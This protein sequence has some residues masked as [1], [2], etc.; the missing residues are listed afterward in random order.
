MADLVRW[1]LLGGRSLHAGYVPYLSWAPI[2]RY[3]KEKVG[4]LQ[5]LRLASAD[6]GSSA[7]R[8]EEEEKNPAGQEAEGASKRADH[9]LEGQDELAG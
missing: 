5:A 4:L 1:A 9:V 3:L 7:V 6:G 8:Q 2:L